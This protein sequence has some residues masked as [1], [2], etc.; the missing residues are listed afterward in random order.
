MRYVLSRIAQSLLALLLFMVVI[1][2]ATRAAGD[3]AQIL[4]PLD[5]SPEEIQAARH[6][7]GTDRSYPEQFVT[8]LQDMLTLNFGR[9]VVHREPVTHL[10]SGRVGASVSLV[11]TAVAMV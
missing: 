3:P 1:F 6:R 9:S 10:L 8:F 2:V 5:A 4:L 11:L 7:F